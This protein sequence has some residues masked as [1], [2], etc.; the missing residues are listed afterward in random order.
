[1]H[2]VRLP[3]IDTGRNLFQHTVALRRDAKV[4]I[5]RRWS[6]ANKD[7]GSTSCKEDFDRLFCCNSKSTKKIVHARLI[8]FMAHSAA[9]LKI[10][11]SRRRAL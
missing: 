5:D 8:Y 1:M 9:R 10:T 2:Q 4:N 6:P 11:R 7:G 3:G